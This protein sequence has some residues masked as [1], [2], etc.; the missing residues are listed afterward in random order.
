MLPRQIEPRVRAA[1][2]RFP[3][4]ALLGARQVGKTTLARLIAA[5]HG[6]GVEMLD[7]ERPSDLAKLAEPELFLQAHAA[8]LVV[9]DEVQRSPGLFAVLRALVD[10]R[11]RPGRFLLLG[12]AT[13]DL[14]RQSAESLAGRIV[15]HELAPLCLAEVGARHAGRLW[16]RGGFPASFLAR[17][18]ADSFRWR[19]AFVATHL[20]RDLP[21]LGIRVPLANL[22]RFWQMLAHSHGQLWNASKIGASLG[23]TGPTVRHYLD[24]LTATYMVRELIPYHVNVKK[25]LVKAPKVYVRDSGL[26][27]TLLGLR[28][29]GGLLGHPVCGASWEGWVIEQILSLTDAGARAGFYRTAAGAELDLVLDRPG[30]PSIGFEIKRTAAPALSKGLRAAIDDLKLSQ[31]YVVCPVR[32]RYPL[33]PQVDALPVEALPDVL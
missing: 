27:H 23:I 31:T 11:R 32:K 7:L 22:R 8:E 30:K 25:R 16:L 12:S 14:L 21:Q 2:R 3:V 28:G 17:S 33:A 10:E 13:P 29:I 26:L 1:L 18:D 9:L 20:E 24:I 15:Y 4:V 5:R 19:E 6:R